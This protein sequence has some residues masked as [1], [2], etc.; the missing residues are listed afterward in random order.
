MSSVTRSQQCWPSF[1]YASPSGMYGVQWL[2]ILVPLPLLMSPVD[3][4]C[5]EVCNHIRHL[6]SSR[7]AVQ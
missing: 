6:R 3:F 7:T 1:S 2:A 4:Q 5:P